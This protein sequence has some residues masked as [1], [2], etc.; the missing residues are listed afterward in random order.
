MHLPLYCG[1]VCRE[2]IREIALGA[3]LGSWKKDSLNKE[4]NPQHRILHIRCESD[5]A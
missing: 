4:L 2:L 1:D 5:K 3:R